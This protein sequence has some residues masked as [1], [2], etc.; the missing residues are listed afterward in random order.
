MERGNDSQ[1]RGVR[2]GDVS[3]WGG[4]VT[5]VDVACIWWGDVTSVDVG[6][7]RACVF[8]CGIISTMFMSFWLWGVHG[9][10]NNG[11]VPVWLF[12]RG[13]MR[14]ICSL[15]VTQNKLALCCETTL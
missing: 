4:D 11:D 8:L 5:S 2:K 15:W 10:E 9:D 6:G 14:G 1:W 12:M 7:G 13:A 3:Q